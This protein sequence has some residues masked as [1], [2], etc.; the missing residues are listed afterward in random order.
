[1]RRATSG[2][3]RR[4]RLTSAWNPQPSI[5]TRMDM[6]QLDHR[7]FAAAS[8][9]GHLA[10][11]CA[12]A[13]GLSLRYLDI[14]AFP[15]T[16]PVQVQINTVAPVAGPGG[17]RAADHLSHR[18]GD[19]RPAGP[20]EHAVAS[21]SSACRK[22]SSRS[23]TAP[24]STSPANWSTNGWRPSSWP[25]ASS[26]RRWG[27]SP[28]AWAKSFTTSSPATGNDVTELRTIH[29]WVIKP[30]MRTVQ[31]R[32]RDQQLGRLRKAVPGAHRSRTC[33]SST[34]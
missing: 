29:D 9:A 28:P 5:L 10:A 25:R 1:M 24:T 27:R 11:A 33:S 34:A 18:A 15:D 2:N 21:R 13:G 8:A 17:S 20:G 7:L 32:G 12:V 30:K 3:D 16:T 22:S 26:G 6:R 19:R 14:D 23:R 4:F 31:G